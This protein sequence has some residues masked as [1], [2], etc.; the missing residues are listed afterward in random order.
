M[1]LTFHIEYV[2]LS[3]LLASISFA[4]EQQSEQFPVTVN[5]SFTRYHKTPQ[6]L[7]NGE[8]NFLRTI[9]F[10]KNPD[11]YP[12]GRNDFWLLGFSPLFYGSSHCHGNCGA[13]A[14]RAATP[15]R[16]LSFASDWPSFLVRPRC[17]PRDFIVKVSLFQLILN[18]WTWCSTIFAFYY[19]NNPV[20]L[21][22]ILVIIG[23]VF[24]L[25]WMYWAIVFEL[26]LYDFLNNGGKLN[27]IWMATIIAAT[28]HYSL[29]AFPLVW[30]GKFFLDAPIIRP[31]KFAN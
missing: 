10:Y 8:K 14:D 23:V 17:S 31:E 20:I 13:S 25:Y 1:I 2:C 19:V 26:L 16:F 29:R 5:L 27:E 9:S 15:Y 4:K 7:K 12:G 24:K 18:N 30:Y 6:T 28:R 11:F 22:L 21:K 3:Y